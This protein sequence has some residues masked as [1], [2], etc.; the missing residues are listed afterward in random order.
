MSCISGYP[1]VAARS[2][3]CGAFGIV[4]VLV[5]RKDPRNRLL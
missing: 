4:F 5:E 2:K 1:R 3:L